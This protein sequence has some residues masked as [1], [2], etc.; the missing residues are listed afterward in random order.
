MYGPYT[1]YRYTV[2]MYRTVRSILIRVDLFVFFCSEKQLFPG[3]SGKVKYHLVDDYDGSFLV[4]SRT[5][6]LVAM[7]PFDREVI[8]E[9]QLRVVAMDMGSPPLSSTGLF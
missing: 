9:Y 2:C 3:P 6:A 8:E 5:G 4:E 7:K 1:A